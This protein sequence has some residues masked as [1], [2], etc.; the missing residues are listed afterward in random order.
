[1]LHNLI[2]FSFKTH[3]E[4]PHIIQHIQTKGAKLLLS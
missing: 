1:L 4:V 2:I 3:S